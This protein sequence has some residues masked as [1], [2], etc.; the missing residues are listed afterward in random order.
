MEIEVNPLLERFLSLIARAQVHI[1]QQAEID[2]HNALV[3]HHNNLVELELF[4]QSRRSMSCKLRRLASSL[5]HDV[6]PCFTSCASAPER[7]PLCS[8]L[9]PTDPLIRAVL[10][11]QASWR[12]MLLRNRVVKRVRDMNEAVHHLDEIEMLWVLPCDTW[13]LLP[14]APLGREGWAAPDGRDDLGLLLGDIY[15][16]HRA[17][18]LFPSIEAA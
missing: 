9:P 13:L 5:L 6:A 3:A 12:R 15:E 16:M 17:R 1:L 2:E 14:P 11:P 4:I 18:L 8:A 10:Y 7:L